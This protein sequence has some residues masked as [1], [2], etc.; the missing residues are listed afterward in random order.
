M[1]TSFKPDPNRKV[2]LESQK[3]YVAKVQS[4]FFEKYL[5]GPSVLDIGFAGHGGDGEPIVPQ[6]IG[7]D[8][9]FPG[10]DGVRLPF[11]DES[12]DAVYSSHCFE[13]IADFRSTLREWHRVL[14]VGGFMIIVV[15]H[16]HLFEKRTA[17]PSSWNLD[18]KRFYTPGSL[19]AEVESSLAPNSFRVR[20]MCDND[21]GYDYGIAPLDPATGCFEIELVLEKIAQPHWDNE[22]GASRIYGV[23]QF[24]ST[25]ARN[26]AWIDT[27]FSAPPGYW[28]W[29]PY[30]RLAR[31]LYSVELFFEAKGLDETEE[32][33]VPIRIDIGVE[34]T[35]SGQ[36]LLLE[37]REG[38]RQL[39][40]GR[41]RLEFYND[42]PDA[43]HEF[44]IWLGGKPFDGAL[45]FYGAELR[46][47]GYAR[48][49]PIRD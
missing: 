18:H 38:A 35:E 17:P 16:Q 46:Y 20:H 14:R 32:L 24:F 44:R 33:A 31:G 22:D 28:I 2:G 41:V 10:Y 25:R 11:P 42:Q 4:G 13:H 21:D 43:R 6:A 34:E 12:Q 40:D 36:D 9:D 5:S 39:R 37:G 8:K 47:L 7:V 15:P 49:L 23:D 1:C 26:G 45:R 19:L 29:G 27:D 30:A 48:R 3:S